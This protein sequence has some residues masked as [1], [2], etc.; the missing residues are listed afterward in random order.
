M[1]LMDV[2]DNHIGRRLREI[3]SWQQLSLTAVAGLAGIT[4]AYLS[5]IER[6]LRPV[7][8][9]KTLESLA[10]ALRVSPAELTGKPWD[11][12]R[13][14]WADT[15]PD[16][17]ALAAALDAYELGDDPGGEVRGEA[18]GQGSEQR[19]GAEGRGVENGLRG[20][21]GFDHD[22]RPCQLLRDVV[23]PGGW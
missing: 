7:T 1:P 23:T 5:M 21:V 15:H 13:Q 3:R 10:Q 14:V 8:K 2:T 22:L 16:L 9:R 12:P 4:P 19:A 20:R 17:V 6:G 18:V 11:Q